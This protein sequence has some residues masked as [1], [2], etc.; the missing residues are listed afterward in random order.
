MSDRRLVFERIGKRFGTVD[1]VFDLSLTVTAGEVVCLLGPSG[2]GKSTSLRIA[3]GVVRQDSGRVRIDGRLVAGEG[4]FIPPE[5]RG[6][7]LMF[8]DYALFPHLT[9]AENVAFGLPRGGD[10][11][12]R[13]RAVLDQVHMG[14]FAGAYPSTLSGGEQ[15]RVALAR[16]LAPSPGIMLMDEPFSGLDVIKRDAIRDET[17]RVLKEAGAATLLVT[18]DPQEAMRMADRIV[19]MRAGRIV[20]DGTPREVYTKPADPDA[21]AFFSDLNLFTATVGAGAAQTPFG[22]V[23]AN[24]HADGARVWVL[25]RPHMLRVASCDAS[26]G[27]PA[28]VVRARLLGAESLI[29]AELDGAGTAK[30]VRIMDPGTVLPDPGTRIGVEADSSRFFVFDHGPDDAASA[31]PVLESGA[32]DRR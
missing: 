7:G 16:A 9:V 32:A 20:Q 24:G 25:A 4:T 28:R 31:G 3:A 12:A 26:S 8:Q 6:I 22:P 18:H 17:W 1:A 21:A 11:A 2:C 29:D 5:G 19:L 14:R 10:R 30:P 15:Q 13:V 27:L 23:P